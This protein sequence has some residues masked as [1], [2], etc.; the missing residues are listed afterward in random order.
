M[1]YIGSTSHLEKRLWQHKNKFVKS[2]TQK[3]N[4]NILIYYEIYE[5]IGSAALREKQL[6]NWCRKKKIGLI[7]KTNPTFKE[8]L[9]NG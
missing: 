6:K 8:L 4:I 9:L 7:K 2:Y 5:T 1:F 3:Y